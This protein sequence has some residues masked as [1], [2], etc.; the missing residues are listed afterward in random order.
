MTEDHLDK[1]CD[2]EAMCFSTPWSKDS[3]KNGLDNNLNTYLTALTDG[4]IVGYICLF[5]IFDEGEILN[6]AVSPDFRKK[7]IA[8]MLLD[9]SFEIFYDKEVTR[10]MLEVRPS[11]TA[12]HTLYIKNGFQPLAVRKNYYTSPTEDGLVMEKSLDERT[13]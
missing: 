12:A 4:E 2:I 5:H 11:N 3:F 10:V 9:K 7:G 6:V 8:Q 13:I 1:I